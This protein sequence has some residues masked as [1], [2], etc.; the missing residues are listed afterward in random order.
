MNDLVFTAGKVLW[1]VLAPSHFIV[2]L[3]ILSLIF[4]LPKLLRVFLQGIVV[5]FFLLMLLFPVGEWALLPLEQCL[6]LRSPPMNVNGIVVLGGM[7]DKDITEARGDGELNSAAD[8]LTALLRLHNLYPSVPIVY[9]G[10]SGA[11][12]EGGYTEAHENK[13]RMTGAR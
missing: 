2:I 11:L 12:Q 6:S 8:R 7:L 5:V 10:G 4:S 1:A 9:S 3:L 13:R